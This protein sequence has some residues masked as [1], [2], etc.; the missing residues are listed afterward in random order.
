MKL[1]FISFMIVVMGVWVWAMRRP[2]R[3]QQLVS[4]VAQ[5]GNVDHLI[6]EL[7][8]KPSLVQPRFY[9][10]AM[11]HLVLVDLD[12]A[13]ALTLQVVPIIPEHK[14]VQEWLAFLSTNETTAPFF[15]SEFLQR[16]RRSGCATG[17]G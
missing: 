17:T 10:E 12:L 5:T 13:T 15:G 1:L 11:Q 16:Y 7:Q 9:D 2:S 3:W 4:S 14:L 6:E 8:K